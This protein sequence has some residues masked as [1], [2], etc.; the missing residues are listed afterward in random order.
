MPS[1][2]V[3][4]RPSVSPKARAGPAPD[5]MKYPY[6]ETEQILAHLETLPGVKEETK[7][8]ITRLLNYRAVRMRARLPRG[9]SAAVLVPLFVGRSGDLYVLLSR[10]SDVL[11]TFA[12]DT[13]LPGG[14][15]DAQDV[16]VED[17]AVSCARLVGLPQDRER[18]PLLCVMEPH[19]AK[20]E[21]L[22]TP[23]VFR[24][25]LVYPS[26]STLP[27]LNFS[28]VTSIFAQPLISFLSST[29]YL[30]GG[31]T[32]DP[33]N[34]Y[35]TFMDFPWSDGGAFRLHK[36]LTGR[37]G[38]GI[39][40]VFG[41][42]ASI[43]IKTATI[44]YGRPPEFEV[45]PPNAPTLARQIAHAL[46][47]PANPIRTACEREGIDVNK[48]AA[49]LLRPPIAANATRTVEWENIGTEWKKLMESDNMADVSTKGK[50]SS[51]GLGLRPA[52][53]DIQPGSKGPQKRIEEIKKRAQHQVDNG[54]EESMEGLDA[55]IEEHKTQARERREKAEN[56][57][58]RKERGGERQDAIPDMAKLGEYLDKTPDMVNG[59]MGE[60]NGD[61]KKLSKARKPY[62]KIVEQVK[63][64]LEGAPNE[65]GEFNPK[66][67]FA[68]VP[69]EGQECLK[70]DIK[71][72]REG[73][74][75]GKGHVDDTEGRGQGIE[76]GK[77]DTRRGL[78][79]MK[80]Y[81]GRGG[82]DHN[83]EQT[84]PRKR[85]AKL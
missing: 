19:L 56:G 40:P 75:R 63:R 64:Q 10:R 80:K 32:A 41:L 85:G 43:L 49:R 7:G 21:I 17:T 58:W 12:G 20:G 69:R 74:K 62:P 44:G 38:E 77:E 28:E 82:D 8:C 4:P 76:R 31:R 68:I 22:V 67:L 16:T 29:P 42:T 39:K 72:G 1:D 50:G 26:C 33:K 48:T 24:F 83:A 59:R 78:E 9:P 57:E 15:I 27:N 18:V 23:C 37:E 81:V 34:P 46:L 3:P 79:D 51:S 52:P 60:V 45:Q 36:F 35:H 61:E 14:K 30:S 55:K 47:T 2:G 66:A 25:V 84:F 70:G 6:P 54:S 11:K 13:A 71:A 53:W 65:D 73:T 5:F